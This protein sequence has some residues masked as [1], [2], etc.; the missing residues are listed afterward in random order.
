MKTAVA[1]ARDVLLASDLFKGI[2]I[3][4]NEVPE[5]KLDALTEAKGNIDPLVRITEIEGVYDVYASN[6]PLYITFSI[7]IDIWVSTLKEV[8]AFYFAVDKVMREKG[9]SCSYSEQTTDPD[10]PN[11]QRIIKRYTGS[12]KLEF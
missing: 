7:Q 4:S 12:Y 3:Y 1:E 10:L 8:N 9:W 6:E 5:T 2:P 11:T